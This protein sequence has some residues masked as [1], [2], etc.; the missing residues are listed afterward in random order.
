MR[1]VDSWG[2]EPAK[3]TPAITGDGAGRS[4][5]TALPQGSIRKVDESENLL[6]QKI[7]NVLW[8]KTGKGMNK[9]P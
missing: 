4:E 7:Q 6:N 5:K 8:A 3:Q 2:V 1:P 9:P